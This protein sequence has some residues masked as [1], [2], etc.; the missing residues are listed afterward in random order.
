MHLQA[1]GT[2]AP[3]EVWVRYVEFARW[4]TWSPQIRRVDVMTD[5]LAPGVEGVV[6][7]PL[8]VAV[9]FRIDA[10]DVGARTWT[11]TVHPVG[12]GP[13]SAVELVLQHG[14]HD[15]P[16]GGTMTTLDVAGPG[17]VLMAYAPVAVLALRRL[18]RA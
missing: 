13:L 9:A 12:A 10:V 8:R 16:D 2:A 4:P 17:M 1:T 3:Q 7:G 15:G 6:R 18:V 5:R 11:W 14:V